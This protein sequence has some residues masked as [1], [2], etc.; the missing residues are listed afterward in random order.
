MILNENEVINYIL[1]MKDL[2]II[3]RPD[4]FN[5]SLDS[6]L[7]ANFLTINRTVKKIMDLGTGNGI[8]PIL[9][10]KKSKA[11][12]SAIE[13]QEVSADLAHKN[14]ELNNLKD[15]V[16][17]INDNMLHYKK[18][19][20]EE[21]FD[22]ITCNPPFFKL[23]GNPDQLNNLDQLTLARHE[24]SINLDGIVEVASKLLR[25]RGYFAMVHRA[26]RLDDILS[27][28]NKYKITPKRLQFCHSTLEKNAKIIL[29]EGIKNGENSLAILPP[30]ITH[31]GREYSKVVKD[32]FQGKF[33]F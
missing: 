3:Q 1:D 18:Y 28:F 31:E 4:Y 5:F 2:K 9:L 25:N 19:F 15:R 7:L 23:D 32:L 10:T 26:D 21:F 29:I 6:I 33:N 8:I 11:H 30:F 16:T 12:I 24:I 13:L 17:I 20:E 14:I 27:T 22:A